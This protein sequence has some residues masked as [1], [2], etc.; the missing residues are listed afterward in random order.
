MKKLA[1]FLLAALAVGAVQQARALNYSPTHLLLVFRQDG[2]KDVLFD[3]GS[4]SNYLGHTAGTRIPVAYNQDYVTT[5]FPGGRVGVQFA[6]VSTTDQP[7][8]LQ[9]VW[10]TDATVSATPADMTFSKFSQ[11]S[12]KVDSVALDGAIYTLSNAAP[13]VVAT[14]APS[15]YDY[16]VTYGSFSAVSTLN[17]DAPTAVGGVTA[18]PVDA[19]NPTTLALYQ[20]QISTVIPKPAATLVGAFTLDATGALYFTAGQLPTLAQT[21]ITG[22]EADPLNS[23]SA[24]LSFDTSLG[25]NYKL[26]SAP[27]VSGPWQPVPGAGVAYGDGTVQSLTD[28]NTSDPIRF[29]QIQTTY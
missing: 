1:R 28:Y 7:D 29:Y 4:V 18:L 2:V 13:Y 11:V 20:I 3:I 12:G 16:L 17:G 9:R 26:Y 21:T 15:S 23:M 25:A 19:V 27:S 14:A 24:T 22:I 5:N 6:V 10:L 8:P